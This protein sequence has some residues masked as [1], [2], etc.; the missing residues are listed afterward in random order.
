MVAV[1]DGRTAATTL[2]AFLRF[3]KDLVVSRRR[4]VGLLLVVGG[5]FAWLDFR[6]SSRERLKVRSAARSQ[7][8]QVFL[9]PLRSAPPFALT[10]RALRV[11]HIAVC[12]LAATNKAARDTA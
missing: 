8:A 11:C 4:F 9:S 12:Q 1:P 5:T 10:R 7:R 2:V 6:I 3:T